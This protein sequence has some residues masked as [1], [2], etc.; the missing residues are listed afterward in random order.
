M[1]KSTANKMN[2]LSRRHFMADTARKALGVSV[3]PMLGQSVGAAPVEGTFAPGRA[4]AAKSVIFLNMGGGMTHL[5]TF[6]PKNN[7]DVMGETESIPTNVDGIQLGHNLPLLARQADKLAIINSMHTSQGAHRQGQYILHRSYQPCGTIVHPTLGSRVLR[8]SGK[9]NEP[10]PGYVH[11]GTRDG[12]SSAGFFGPEYAAV[13]IGDPDQGISDI[14]LPGGVTEETFNERLALSEVINGRFRQTFDHRDVRDYENLYGDAIKLMRAEDLKAFDI[15]QEPAAL[16]EEYGDSEFGRA[17]LLA[18]RLIEHNVR[19]VEINKGGW[20]M[21]YN[22]QEALATNGG[23]LDRGF[24][25]LLNDL[26][27]RGLLEE[28]VVALGTEFG[29]TPEI[30]A[31][32]GNGRNHFPR[33]YSCVLAGGGIQGGQK[34]G[35]TDSRGMYVESNEVTPPMFNA[36]IAYAMGLPIDRTI[37]SPSQRPFEVSDGAKPITALF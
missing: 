13:P 19:Y 14:N 25:V 32:H 9:R 30:I 37:Y 26:E 17:C 6:D 28:T 11:V 4:K 10:I 24:S 23:D 20:D 36:T 18:R 8:L 29:R 35:S 2:E 5:D 7:K 1:D 31:E 34:Y 12:T 15:S 33:A 16:R 21:H 27:R 22:L 3:L